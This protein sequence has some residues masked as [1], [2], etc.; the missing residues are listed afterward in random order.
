MKPFFAKLFDV[1][2]IIATFSFV[3]GVVLFAVDSNNRNGNGNQST[4]FIGEVIWFAVIIGLNYVA[5]GKATLWNGKQ[6]QD[7]DSK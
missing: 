7:Q 4:F 3:A 6:R 5:L 1:F 2:T